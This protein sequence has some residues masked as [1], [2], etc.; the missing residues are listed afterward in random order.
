[1]ELTIKIKDKDFDKVTAL[2]KTLNVEII[3]NNTP[4]SVSVMHEPMAKYG[5]KKRPSTD[6]SGQMIIKK[7]IE[8]KADAWKRVGRDEEMTVLANAGLDDFK[9]IIKDYETT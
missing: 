3:E 2:L 9:N 4:S 8:S 7:A 5:Q 1:M 6:E